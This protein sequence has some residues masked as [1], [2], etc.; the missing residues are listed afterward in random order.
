MPDSN[1]IQMARIS[2]NI[3]KLLSNHLQKAIEL[4]KSSLSLGMVQKVTK[5]D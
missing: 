3:H 2:K 5:L 4:E 1:E